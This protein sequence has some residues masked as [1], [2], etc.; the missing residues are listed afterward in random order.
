MSGVEPVGQ[1]AGG[2]FA[3]PRIGLDG[4]DH[5]GDE[6]VGVL[7]GVA[8]EPRGARTDHGPHLGHDQL[9]RYRFARAGQTA[10]GEDRPE[11]G[12]RERRAVGEHLAQEIQTGVHHVGGDAELPQACRVGAL[13]LRAGQ[14]LNPAQVLRRDEVPGRSQDVGAHPVS[15]RLRSHDLGVARVP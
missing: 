6:C 7:G 5:L 1:H 15:A 2:V 4:R 11:L 14:R 10:L 12:A 9:M 13:H 3:W 8:G